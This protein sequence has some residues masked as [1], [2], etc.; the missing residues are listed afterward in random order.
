MRSRCGRCDGGIFGCGASG[1]WRRR[2]PLWNGPF[3]FARV[4]TCVCVCV[5]VCHL[6][7]FS[8]SR[9]SAG[10]VSSKRFRSSPVPSSPVAHRRND[11]MTMATLLSTILVSVGRVSRRRFHRRSCCNETKT[12]ATLQPPIRSRLRSIFFS[13]SASFLFLSRLDQVQKK[14]DTRSD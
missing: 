8:S 6:E 12:M 10:V 4:C 14:K 5:C 2:F 3:S 1:V 11:T 7:L 9:F 13:L